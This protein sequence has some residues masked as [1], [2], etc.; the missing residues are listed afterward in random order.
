MASVNPHST[1]AE[2]PAVAQIRNYLLRSGSQGATSRR[3]PP[4]PERNFG[5]RDF[6]WLKAILA[7]VHENPDAGT[8]QL[9]PQ[10]VRTVKAL[11]SSPG[12]LHH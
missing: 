12:L 6:L 3:N 4:A 7:N 10:R 1:Y 8:D 9:Y 5:V 11:V 2:T